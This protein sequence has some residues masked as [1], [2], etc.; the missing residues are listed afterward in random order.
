MGAD[1]F[2]QYTPSGAPVVSV[3]LACRGGKKDETV[4]LDVKA[5]GKTAENLAQW[6][7]KGNMLAM[8][9]NFKIDVYNDADGGK[10]K[11]H[12]MNADFFEFLPQSKK[13]DPAEKPKETPAEAASEWGADLPF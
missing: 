1:P 7:K 3:S 9:G 2:L 4:W 5:F 6:G 8:A 13:S 12:Y 11:Y 10:K